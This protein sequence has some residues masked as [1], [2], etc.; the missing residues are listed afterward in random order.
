MPQANLSDSPI[1]RVK[2]E[3]KQG[4]VE[5]SIYPI[6]LT[7][8]NLGTFWEKA[9][10]YPNLFSEELKDDFQT[11]LGIFLEQNGDSITARGLLWRIDNFVGV[12]YL[13]DIYPERDAI[14]HFTFFDGRIHG[15]VK[16]AQAM[17]SYVFNKYKFRRLSAQVPMF[18]ASST[19][20][21]IQRVGFTLEGRKRSSTPYKGQWY[22]TKLFGILSHHE[23][24]TWERSPQLLEAVSPQ[25]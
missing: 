1:L 23:V 5:R 18:V 25:A 19:L 7:R 6:A 16:L 3:E 13:T 2:C 24:E 12:F 22:D 15:R 21:F 4:V 14:C 20:E 17:L 11:F 8:E 10:V 9:R